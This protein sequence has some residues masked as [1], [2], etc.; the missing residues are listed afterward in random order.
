VVRG[1]GRRR[2]PVVIVCMLLGQLPGVGLL[3]AQ[4]HLLQHLQANGVC[5]M[6]PCDT[7]PN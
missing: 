5:D 2:E 4:P 7:A 3:H 6:P 1:S